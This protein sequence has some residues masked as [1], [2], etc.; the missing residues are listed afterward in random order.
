LNVPVQLSAAPANPVIAT[1]AATT[2]AAVFTPFQ[3]IM[4]MFNAP[5]LIVQKFMFNAPFLI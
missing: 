3:K 1:H 2:T 4:F 5:L